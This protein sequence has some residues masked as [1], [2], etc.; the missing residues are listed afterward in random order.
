M[1]MESILIGLLIMAGVIG[2]LMY[3]FKKKD[4]PKS[5]PTP[6]VTSTMR[7][8]VPTATAKPTPPKPTTA[9]PPAVRY[10]QNVPQPDPVITIFDD[11][12]I[13]QVRRCPSCDGENQ[14]Y[15]RGCQICGRRL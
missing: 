15:A 1:E 10:N 7:T 5:T 9:T 6:T 14:L 3:L 8:P 2:L 13:R 12:T 4:T 11:K